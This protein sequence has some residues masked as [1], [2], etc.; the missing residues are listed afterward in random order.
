MNNQK[1]HEDEEEDEEDQGGGETGW[2]ERKSGHTAVESDLPNEKMKKKKYSEVQAQCMG[3][4]K[5]D[6]ENKWSS[7]TSLAEWFYCESEIKYFSMVANKWT[8]VQVE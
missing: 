5:I 7:F 3:T 4:I 2:D 1:A 8:S 6:D